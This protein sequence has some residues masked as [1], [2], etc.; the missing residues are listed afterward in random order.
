[1]DWITENVVFPTAVLL[2]QEVNVSS[3]TGIIIFSVA[4]VEWCVRRDR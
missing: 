4:E 3:S 1:M 2:C